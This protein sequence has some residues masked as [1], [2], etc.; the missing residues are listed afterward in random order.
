MMNFLSAHTFQIVVGVLI[1]TNVI[2]YYIGHR[3]VQGVKNDLADIQ[4][5]VQKIKAKVKVK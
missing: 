1:V 2:S 3:G 5:D 4:A